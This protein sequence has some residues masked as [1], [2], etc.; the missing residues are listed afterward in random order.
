MLFAKWLN[1][2]RSNDGARDFKFANP[3]ASRLRRRS[4]PRV[5]TFYEDRG[6]RMGKADVE[7]WVLASTAPPGDSDDTGTDGW[8]KDRILADWTEGIQII[9]RNLSSSSTK[10]RVEFLKG[11]V[12]PIVKDESEFRTPR[13]SRRSRG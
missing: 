11:L 10:N 9:R 12:I 13:G 2:A 6:V 7:D 3:R 4:L 5:P 8:D 1:F